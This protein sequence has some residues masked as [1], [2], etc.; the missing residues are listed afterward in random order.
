MDAPPRRLPRR[1]RDQYGG[2][3]EP[4]PGNRGWKA[5]A[6]RH[7][8]R[9]WDQRLG[10]MEDEVLREDAVRSSTFIL[11]ALHSTP[12]MLTKGSTGCRR[13]TD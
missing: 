2:Y 9:A 5:E 13:S 12:Q 11:S 8:V 6:A 7:M 3:I 10:E 1:S 4:V